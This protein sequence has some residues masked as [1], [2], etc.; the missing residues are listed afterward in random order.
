PPPPARRRLTKP[1][2]TKTPPPPLPSV[3]T[4]IAEAGA[5]ANRYPDLFASGLPARIAQRF[6]V[7]VTHV[8]TG[9]GSVGVCQQ[10]VQATAGPGDEVVYAWRSLGAFPFFARFSGAPRVFCPWPL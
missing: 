1:P 9:T 8:S 10:I 7:P 4:A 6:D 5:Q 2:P 3:L